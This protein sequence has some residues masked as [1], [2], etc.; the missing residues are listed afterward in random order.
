MR[1]LGVIRSLTG[2]QVPPV[3]RTAMIVTGVAFFSALIIF[4]PQ[5]GGLPPAPALTVAA[6]L[7]PPDS[8]LAESQ[9]LMDT[10][11]IYLPSAKSVPLQAAKET[12]QPEDAPLPGFEPILRFSP[13]KPV[14]L[15]L[16]VEKSTAVDPRL[17]TPLSLTEPFKSFGSANLAQGSIVPRGVYFEIY[18][19]SG[20]KKYVLNGNI[21]EKMYKKHFSGIK[22]DKN[23]PLWSSLELRI[24]IDTMGQQAAPMVVKSSGFSAVDLAVRNWAGE[25][26][27]ARRLPPGAYRLIVGP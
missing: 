5:A 23:A 12:I 13:G 7:L 9:G 4:K 18:S 25:V 19:L 20:A 6:E 11:T 15:P 1:L 2:G 14:D 27:W 24:G 8:P 10:S 3:T 16:E 22:N 17:A 26:E 21:D